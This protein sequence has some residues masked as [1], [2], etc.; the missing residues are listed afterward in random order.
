MHHFSLSRLASVTF[1]L[2]NNASASIDQTGKNSSS[3][4]SCKL[5]VSA[6]N[7]QYRLAIWCSKADHRVC[8]IIQ[9]NAGTLA[10]GSGTLADG[11]KWF[12]MDLTSRHSPP[13]VISGLY[14]SIE[15]FRVRDTDRVRVSVRAA[16]YGRSATHFDDPQ[17]TVIS[18]RAGH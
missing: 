14:Q 17:T 10:P 5:I 16:K 2:S 6:G 1:W 9:I 7:R 11:W 13:T 15:W 3:Q 18:G 4:V 12:G 8:T